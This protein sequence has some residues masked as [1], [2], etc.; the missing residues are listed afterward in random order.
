MQSLNNYNYPFLSKYLHKFLLNSNEL[1]KVFFEIEKKILLKR[2][3]ENETS[4]LFITGLARSGSTILLNTL[5]EKN[6]FASLR[7]IDMP[8]ITSP[9]LWSKISIFKKKRKIKERVHN[10][11][12][13][14]DYSSPEAFE[15]VF[16]KSQLNF[17][18]KS[19]LM[20]DPN[21]YSNQVINNFKAY[22]KL[23]CFK[24]N[25]NIYLSKNNNNIIRINTLLESIKK[26]KIIILFRFPFDQCYS[27]WQQHRNF[28]KLQ[29][30]N[31][32][33]LQY[34]N[35]LSH[36]EFGLN[37]KPILLSEFKPFHSADDLNYWLEYWIMIYSNLTHIAKKNNK[38]VIFL[39]YEKLALSPERFIK[40]IFK[41]LNIDLKENKNKIYNKEKNFS[42]IEVKKHILEK[43]NDLYN[44]LKK[45]EIEF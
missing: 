40:K 36:Y 1:L 34:M 14:I 8:F 3:N 22:M 9:N 42:K 41:I 28:I 45:F 43:A 38:D 37:H 26:K 4:S 23:V 2:A 35:M 20:H 27:L 16:W 18:F 32:F 10:D 12:I 15:E 5:Y 7:Y 24:E 11:G 33:I 19:K 6:Y 39:S 30:K 29:K 13:S 31:N 25:K 21:H 44:N 17:N